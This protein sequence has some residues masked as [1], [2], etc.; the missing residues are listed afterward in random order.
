MSHSAQVIL[1]IGVAAILNSHGMGL[2]AAS[3]GSCF[4]SRAR[5]G[6]N[7]I[8]WGVDG[9]LRRA[10]VSATRVNRTMPRPSVGE[11][12]VLGADRGESQDA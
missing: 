5:I 2:G 12:D 7:G 8:D 1:A 9:F 10:R 3:I 11:M 4:I 6:S